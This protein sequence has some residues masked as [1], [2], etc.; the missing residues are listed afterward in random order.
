M[1]GIK[2][3]DYNSMKRQFAD[4]DSKNSSNNVNVPENDISA[5]DIPSAVVVDPV[6][7][8][9]I[10]EKSDVDTTQSEFNDDFDDDLGSDLTVEDVPIEQSSVKTSVPE[11]HEFVDPT[12][13]FKQMLNKDHAESVVDI[14][15]F[16][17]VDDFVSDEQDV[18][19]AENIETDIEDDVDDT[20]DMDQDIEEETAESALRQ[21]TAEH[22]HKNV[23][24]SITN[25]VYNKATTGNSV[26]K[27]F[28]TSLVQIARNSFPEEAV[29][30]NTE[31]VAAYIYYKEGCPPDVNVPQN[32]KNIAKL[33]NRGGVT[34]EDL[35]DSFEDNMRT[36][37]AHLRDLIKIVHAIELGVAYGLCDHIGFRTKDQNSPGE[38]EFLEQA[39]ID[40]V[41]RL[42]A[43]SELNQGRISARKG[44][45]FR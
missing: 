29:S 11:K 4:N 35:Q 41:K 33:Y 44:S 20:D 17:D 34:T 14:A 26:L 25:P 5:D 7:P 40:V 38:L 24:K 10:V 28:P 43:Q 39:I 19:S 22:N 8:V 2:R 36:V 15:D 30:N 37:D 32:I 16:D 45:Q 3:F 18:I 9:D 27:A 13:D 6:D 31:A 42:N 23:P 1:S 12:D 21:R